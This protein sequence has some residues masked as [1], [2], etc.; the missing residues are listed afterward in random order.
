[1]EIQGFGSGC[2]GARGEERRERT[3]RSFEHGYPTLQ[4]GLAELKKSGEIRC[5]GRG[6]DAEWERIK[7]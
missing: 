7:G 5:L 1:M 2:L 4:R 6:P 3:M